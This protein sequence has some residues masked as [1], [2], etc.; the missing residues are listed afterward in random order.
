MY[1]LCNFFTHTSIKCTDNKKVSEQKSFV[2][3]PVDYLKLATVSPG[4]KTVCVNRE[5]NF[6]SCL[7]HAGVSKDSTV[8]N[9]YTQIFC[10]VH[11]IL[12]NRCMQV[13]MRGKYENALGTNDIVSCHQ[14]L[15]LSYWLINY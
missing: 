15:T 9:I 14:G 10:T 8:A 7:A 13:Q 1:A 5:E 6:T 12:S 2:A 3:T 11:K 4:L